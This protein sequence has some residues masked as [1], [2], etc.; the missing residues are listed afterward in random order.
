VYGVDAP[1]VVLKRSGLYL[2]CIGGS[3]AA[4]YVVY[5]SP[6]FNP[7]YKL[8]FCNPSYSYNQMHCSAFNVP[9][10]SRRV[11]PN[12]N[13]QG[14]FSWW[15]F[16]KCAIFLNECI[17]FANCVF[18][19]D[20]E[21][22]DGDELLELQG[23]T[24]AEREAWLNDY[25]TE[26]GI[27]ANLKSIF[28]GCVF[29]DKTSYDIWNDPDN[30]DMT[31]KWQNCDEELV[32]S[33]GGYVGALPPALHVPIMDDSSEQPG[34]WD[35]HTASGLIGV[36]DNNIILRDDMECSEGEI[37][38]K[39]IVT[40]PNRLSISGVFGQMEQQY[41]T[42]GIQAGRNFPEGEHYAVGET[43]PEGRYIARGG[44][45]TIGENYVAENGIIVV[46]E[47]GATV[48][49]ANETEEENAYVVAI[50]DCNIVD[51][52]F[53][54]T[55]PT[56]Y[57]V[58]KST[59]GLQGGA[60]Y[61]NL[62]NKPIKYRGRTIVQNESFIAENDEDT[63]T[64]ESDADYRIGVIFDDTRVPSQPWIPAQL[65]GEYFVGKSGAQYLKDSEGEFISSGNYLSFQTSANGGYSPVKSKGR[66][67]A[68]YIQLKL[69]VKSGNGE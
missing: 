48:T 50:K 32:D 22:Y 43:L 6:I 45:V 31:L 12:T 40:N 35:E 33:A 55:C 67:Q 44:G 23:E 14:K 54:R 4:K 58:I 10:A 5:A 69:M 28:T 3:S 66:A 65:F 29:S 64:C 17:T 15:I 36:V 60:T 41:A 11:N 59:D 42:H 49:S 56:A 8:W 38:S 51:S 34:T 24:S 62:F 7:N 19:S 61:L 68:R 26:K 37:T 63:F 52:V 53:I 46:G 39:L 2:G 1:S 57:A 18:A 16:G 30:A 47:E 27:S 20:C 13:R 9:K 25:I 21:F